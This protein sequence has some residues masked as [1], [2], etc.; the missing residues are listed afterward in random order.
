MTFTPA[1]ESTAITI[2]A[3]SSA[4]HRL[5]NTDDSSTRVGFIRDGDTY[6]N[7]VLDGGDSIEFSIERERADIRR[8]G[9]DRGTLLIDDVCQPFGGDDDCVGSTLQL[10][11]LPSVHVPAGITGIV[12]ARLADTRSGARTFDGEFAG[13]GRV[14][15][16]QVLTVKVTERAKVPA[17][18]TAGVFNVTAVNPAA[19]GFLTVFPC[20]AK[21]TPSTSNVNYVAGQIVPNSVFA[22]FSEAGTICVFSKAETD[23]IVDVNGYV[24]NGARSFARTPVRL[25][26]T[27]A[28]TETTD[29]L[30]AGEGPVKGGTVRALRVRGRSNLDEFT[31]AVFLNVTAVAPSGPGF[32]T[33]YA[34]D[35]PELPTASNVNYVAGQVVANA[36]LTEIAAD[37]TVCIFSRADADVVVDLTGLSQNIAATTPVTPQ[38]LLET[39]TGGEKTTDGKFQGEGPLKAGTVKEIQVTGRGGVPNGVTA[40]LLN[41]TAVAPGGPGF[42]TVYPCNAT[43]TPVTSNVNYLPG[44]VVA[45]AALSR[46]SPTGTVCVFSKAD[47]DVLIDVNGYVQTPSKF[48]F[49]FF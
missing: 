15:A 13:G 42:L 37:G 19:A 16:G 46:L 40:A 23:V 36:V 35:V 22:R 1:D 4:R 11:D 10:L 43:E 29:G 33:V 14:K 5:V 25:M 45:N 21:E 32:L 6:R 48:Q 39:R 20:D 18:A 24:P 49:S 34:C 31:R 3:G 30:A 27:R 26:D 8:I 2:D 9:I 38:R 28:G 17:T 47:A 41:V 7:V 12:P 44:Q